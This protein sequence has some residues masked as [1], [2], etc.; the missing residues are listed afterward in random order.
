MTS[1]IK[2]IIAIF[3]LTVCCSNEK[4]QYM[5][6]EKDL[7]ETTEQNIIE[8]IVIY[9]I[10]E[11][12]Q[13]CSICLSEMIDDIIKIKCNHKF[14]DRCLDKWIENKNECPI[15]RRHIE[16]PFCK[17]INI[18]YKNCSCHGFIRNNEIFCCLIKMTFV[19]SI[20]AFGIF[21]GNSL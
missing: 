14:H 16:I 8:P 21:V 5:K 12:D 18:F 9:P 19:T 1:K 3:Y 11:N 6:A 13:N 4:N 10:V 7:L 2:I 17:K 15:C 20:F